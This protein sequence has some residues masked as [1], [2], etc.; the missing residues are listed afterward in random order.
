MSSYSALSSFSSRVACSSFATAVKPSVSPATGR[1]PSHGGSDVPSETFASEC[2][3]LTADCSV[4]GPGW[5]SPVPQFGGSAATDVR[6][7]PS[8]CQRR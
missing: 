6:C 4:A 3:M 7:S 1:K 2:A 5:L 8:R